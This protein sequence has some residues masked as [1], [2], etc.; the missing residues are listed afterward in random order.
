MQVFV[1]IDMGYVDTVIAH[2]ADL[3]CDFR[4][5]LREVELPRD[6]SDEQRPLAVKPAFRVGQRSSGRE[7]PA[8]AKIQVDAEARPAREGRNPL[9]AVLCP[10][11]VRHDRGAGQ[12]TG[13]DPGADSRC[14]RRG[15]A[16]I[17][18]MDDER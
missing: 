13:L 2:A 1:A 7:G 5:E 18:G 14:D 6:G 17:V 4:L 11:H 3:R 8:F 12:D 10:R 9:Q 16:E 15:L